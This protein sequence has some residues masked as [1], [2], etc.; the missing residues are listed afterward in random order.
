MTIGQY[1]DDYDGEYV[2]TSTIIRDGK[3]IQEREWIDNP[4]S[5]QHISNRAAVLASAIDEEFFNFQ[6][7]HNHRGGLFSSKKL[8]LYGTH[9]LKDKCNLN[10]M[11]S[12]DRHVLQELIDENID[13]NIVCY[14]SVKNCLRYPAHF[15]L[16]PH[17]PQLD[18]RASALYCAAFDG[19]K[20]IFL[21]GFHDGT[22][23]REDKSLSAQNVNSVI[24]AYPGTEF[25]FVGHRGAVPELWDANDN[26]SFMTY[27]NWVSYCDIG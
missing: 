18:E 10:F 21:L 22:S 2:L 8:Q 26:F 19:H 20:E 24:A 16:I 17:T 6:L 27:H 14:T 12:L 4:I 25:Y 3:K 5:N 9:A 15:Y 7:L 23:N 13:E 11:V 1:R